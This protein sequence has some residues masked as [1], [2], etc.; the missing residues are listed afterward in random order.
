MSE[1][2]TK[3]HENLYYDRHDLRRQKIELGDTWEPVE[4]LLRKLQDNPDS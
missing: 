3:L 1:V 2:I 4:K